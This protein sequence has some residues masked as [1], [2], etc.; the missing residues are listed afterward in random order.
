MNNIKLTTTIALACTFACGSEDNVQFG[1]STSSIHAWG[2]YHWEKG[3]GELLLNLG[4][5]LSSKWQ[6]HLVQASADWNVSTVV[7][8]TVV[9]GHSNR[10]CKP[11]NGRVEVCNGKYGQ[12]G[13]LG[14][15]QI[16]LD[17]DHIVKAVTKVNDTYFDLP[18][19]NTPAWRQLVMCQE[20][21]H[22]FG[23]GHQDED[24]N[25]PNLGTCMDYTSDPSTNTVPNAHDYEQLEIIY[26]HVETPP[27]EEPPTG[28][29]FPPNSKKCRARWTLI[30]HIFP[31]PDLDEH[32]H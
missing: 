4:D 15:A 12:T 11:V 19:Y 2:P 24:F 20:I 13:W 5:N 26:D 18:Q 25:N 22:D 3:E 31:V 30:E 23:L 10:N 1:H 21:A 17:G 6:A 32:K 14:I 16:W 9:D 29:C 27:G 7:E 8:T 28:G